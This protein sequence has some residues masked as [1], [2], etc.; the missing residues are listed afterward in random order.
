GNTLFLGFWTSQS[1]EGFQQGEYIAVYASLGAA[2][3]IFTFIVSYCVVIIGINASFSM[4]R[5]ALSGVLKSP[6]AFF[7]TTPMGRV[8][9]RLSK[10]QDTLDT[11]LPFNMLQ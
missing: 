8:L 5:T 2:Q 9:S 11:L 1:I 6:V 7:D 4:F 3:A 10:D